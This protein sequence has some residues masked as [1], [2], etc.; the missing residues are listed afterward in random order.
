M[1]RDIRRKYVTTTTSYARDRVF[2]A[3]T[4]G[5]PTAL[6]NILADPNILAFK[7]AYADIHINLPTGTR[8]ARNV[9][10]PSTMAMAPYFQR[11]FPTAITLQNSI[12]YQ[13]L[14]IVANNDNN[15]LL[16]PRVDLMVDTGEPE[17]A[18]VAKSFITN[19]LYYVGVLYDP[20]DPLTVLNG[21]TTTTDSPIFIMTVVTYVATYIT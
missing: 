17:L 5:D 20:L 4:G 16:F 2:G 8:W 1:R 11:E 18:P 10:A 12:T 6:I 19:G 3:S 7:E 15:A 21:Y 14:N 9:T 13:A